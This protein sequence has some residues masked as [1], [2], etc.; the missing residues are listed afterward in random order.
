M[1]P[2]TTDKKASDAKDN[3]DSI[4]PLID[5]S[6]IDPERFLSWT[7]KDDDVQSVYGK[8]CLIPNKALQ[9]A[10]SEIANELELPIFALAHY[11]NKVDTMSAA[12][13]APIWTELTE[14]TSVLDIGN[15]ENYELWWKNLIQKAVAQIVANH[16]LIAKLLTN[17]H[18]RAAKY[19]C[20]LID[21]ALEKKTCD[22]LACDCK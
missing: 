10:A 12:V 2:C 18:R 21:E 6:G 11:G 9:P 19:L 8:L 20:K 13:C 4:P 15:P 5:E 7:S 22:V 1:M 14:A 16:L 3:D 17:K